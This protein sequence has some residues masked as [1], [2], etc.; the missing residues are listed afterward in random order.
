[1]PVIPL[2]GSC[3]GPAPLLFAVRALTYLSI[4]PARLSSPPA[5]QTPRRISSLM[6]LPGERTLEFLPCD[7]KHYTRLQRSR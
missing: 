4:Q 3:F 2:K 6:T 5:D 1:M 7:T